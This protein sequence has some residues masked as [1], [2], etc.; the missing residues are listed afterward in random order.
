MPAARRLVT[1]SISHFCEKARWALDR[2]GLDYVEEGHYPNAH[3]IA[4][5][6]LARQPTMPILVDGGKVIP[7]STAI[8]HHLDGRL[9]SNKRL[10]PDGTAAT[11]VEKL[12]EYFDAELGPAA[13]RWAYWHWF[14]VI[15]KLVKYGGIHTPRFERM[16][17]PY[18]IH[19]MKHMTRIRLK[20]TDDGARDS[21]AVVHQVFDEVG[22]RLSDGRRYLTGDRFTAADL[23]FAALVAPVLLPPGHG[24]PMPALDEAPPAMREEIERLRTTPAGKFALRLYVE[25]RHA[26][27]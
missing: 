13:R 14:G 17:A 16:M 1:I 5:F 20:V 11:E 26:R 4:S 18:V 6:M 27:A 3:Y 21:L 24:V 25:D 8:I 12:E 23:A 2:T 19:V 10:F 7:D 15:G 22:R 9:P